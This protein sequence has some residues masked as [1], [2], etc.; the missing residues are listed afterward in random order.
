MAGLKAVRLGLVV[1]LSAAPVLAAGPSVEAVSVKALTMK[2]AMDQ[3]V[4]ISSVLRDAR[5]DISKKKLE[6]EQA[7]HAV[8]SEEAKASGLFAKPRNL[9]QDLT[10]RLKVPEASKQLYLAQE[11]LRQS[12]NTVRFDVQKA[13]LTAYQDEAAEE[14]A[15]KKWEDAKT[16]LD[17][18]KKKRK[19]GLADSAEQEQ[20]EKA[21]EKAASVY[22]Q[23]QLTAKASRLALGKLLQLDMENKVQLSFEP[24]YANLDQKQLPAYITSGLKSTVSLLKDTEDR[25]LADHKL[26]TTRDLYSSKFGSSRM[27]VMDGLYKAKDIDMDMFLASYETT[28]SQVKKDW[29]GFFLLLGF[30]PI[31]K[32]LLQ[33]EFDGLRYLDDLRDALPIATMEQNKAVLQEK[34]SRSAVIAAVRASYMEAKGAEEG[35]AQALRD[36][37]SAVSALDKATQKVK[38]SLMKTDE[39]AAYKEAVSKADEQI[40]MAQMS[41]ETALGKLDIDTGGAV[42]KTLKK[43]ILPYQNLDDG[44]AAVKTQNPKAPAGS[45]KLKPAVGPLLSDF[46]VTVNKKL[47]ATDYALF[48]KDGRAIGKRTKMN[49]AVRQLTLKLSQLENLKVV[50]YAKGK[51]IGELLLEGKGNAGQLAAADEAKDGP[52]NGGN[53]GSSVGDGTTNGESASGADEEKG[54]GTVIIGSYKVQLDAL[55]PEAYNAASATMSSSGQG[56]FYKAD[57][58]GAVWFG[59]DNAVDPSAIADPTSSAA[60]SQ[61]DA[62]ALKVTVEIAKPGAI[63]SLQTPEQLQQQIDTLKKDI[64]KLEAAKE[65]AVTDMKLSEI[66]DLAVEIKDAQAQLGMLEAL[67]KGDSQAALQQ[68]EL[69]N[70][71]DALIAALSEETETPPGSPGGEVPPGGTTP[72]KEAASEDALAEQAEL[73]QTKLEQALA[74]GEPVAAAAV[75]QQLLATQAQLADAQTGASEGQASLAEAKQKLEAALKLAQAQGDTER[76]ATLTRSLEAVA[77]AV[78]TAKKDAL[79]AQLDAVQVLAAALPQEAG[80]QTQLEQQVTKLLKELQQQEKAKYTPEEQAALADVSAALAASV[81]VQPLPAENV[82]SPNIFIKFDAPPVIINGQAYLPIRS[83]SESFGAAVDW[84][85]DT[86]TVTVSTE[87]KTI[88]SRI[89]EDKAYVDGDPVQIDGPAYLLEGKTYVPLRFIAESLGLQVDWNAPTQI[90]QISN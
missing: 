7:Q 44:L 49:K 2:E 73:Q 1:L 19:F 18:V 43:G 47:G 16:A 75:L 54:L 24:D 36:K 64:V 26:S 77:E 45:W 39:L 57:E 69:V 8:K 31:P 74:A 27:K 42:A 28:L 34:E 14:N 15:R 72:G 50:L 35:Y 65:A 30:I 76:V 61:K 52:E 56:I 40:L 70:N 55:T 33:G 66:A 9:S 13:Y 6:L 23:A 4:K 60:L 51:P 37:D 29:E 86:L 63:A 53:G 21:L 90:I 10:I 11:T 17:T 82:L 89:S 3:G 22:K 78:A 88:T 59:M 84:D 83:V 81:S 25:R 79:F 62:E 12:M 38:L 71:P 68:M 67:Q 87:Y 46:S 41:Y 85:Q 20:A 58:P 32:S 5:T 80:V 48:T